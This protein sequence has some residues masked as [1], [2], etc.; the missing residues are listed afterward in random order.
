MEVDI[1]VKCFEN[2]GR[3]HRQRKARDAELEAGKG[4]EIDHSLEPPKQSCQHLELK[5]TPE[6]QEN[7]CVLF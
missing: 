4:R 5:L 1:G 6:V 7:K 2:K 3:G